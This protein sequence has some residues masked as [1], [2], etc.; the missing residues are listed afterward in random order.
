MRGTGEIV[1]IP[2][3]FDSYESSTLVPGLL[4]WSAVSNWRNEYQY[5]RNWT[6][7]KLPLSESAFIH[8]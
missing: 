1:A 6:E 2:R 4:L 5:E 7:T 8:G 3:D